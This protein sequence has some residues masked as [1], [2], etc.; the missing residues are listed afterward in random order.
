MNQ[1]VLFTCCVWA[2]VNNHVV[3]DLGITNDRFDADDVVI[4]VGGKVVV[5]TRVSRF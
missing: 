3:E 4:F 2:S 1:M 5:F